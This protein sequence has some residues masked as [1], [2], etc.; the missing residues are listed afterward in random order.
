MSSIALPELGQASPITVRK[1]E[2]VLFYQ[3]AGEDSVKGS[4][5]FAPTRVLKISLANGEKDF[6]AHIAGI[7]E[8]NEMRIN[9]ASGIPFLTEDE[10]YPTVKSERTVE[11]HRDGRRYLHFS[12]G[13]YFHHL[14]VVIDYETDGVW[15]GPLTTPELVW[16]PRFQRLI[17][18]GSRISIALI[19]DSISTGANA[20]GTVD[21]YPYQPS[22]EKLLIDSIQQKTVGVVSFE[23]FARGGMGAA[24]GREQITR[25]AEK[26]ANLVIIA[27]GM[28]DASEL[29]S[30]E[31]FIGDI[32]CMIEEVRK[33]PGTEVLIISG[34][35]PNPA[36]SLAEPLRRCEYHKALGS[37][38][39]VGVAVADV[40]SVWDA[41]VEKKGFWSVTG[42]GVNHPNDFGHRLYARVLRGALGLSSE[43]EGFDL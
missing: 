30:I 13:N 7:G 8:G 5:L 16:L 40:R 19:G 38:R 35:S 34:M 14:Q 21:A 27:F 33:N 11:R 12:E 2:P 18:D 39:D 22:Y 25:V 31:E 1:S 41:V 3:A 15:E 9:L 10:L 28:N 29:R 20:S 4:L 24:W 43:S 17:T 23:N 32:K 26:N 6:P 37:L 36:W 42:N